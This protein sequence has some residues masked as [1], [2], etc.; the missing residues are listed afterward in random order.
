[1]EQDPSDETAFILNQ[2]TGLL[3][4]PKEEYKLLSVPANWNV[5][6]S[7]Q[8]TRKGQETIMTNAQ[9]KKEA[10]AKYAEKVRKATEKGKLDKLKP[11]K[12]T[13]QAN[14]QIKRKYL[15]VNALLNPAVR[16]QTQ[17]NIQSNLDVYFGIIS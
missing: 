11:Q 4:Y 10:G 7:E 16:P 14:I 15:R 8:I 13:K 5:A 17:V 1:M 2:Y 12:Q 6:A 9:K 3:G